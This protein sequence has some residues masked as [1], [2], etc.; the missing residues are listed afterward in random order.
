MSSWSAMVNAVEGMQASSTG[1]SSVSQNIANLNTA[2]YKA[3][4]VTFSDVLSSITPH[5]NIMGVQAV[6]QNQISVQGSIQTTQNWSDVALQ[7]NGFF[8]VNSAEAGS[9][10]TQFTRDGSFV[11]TSLGTTSV[12]TATGTT[13]TSAGATYLTNSTGQFIMGWAAG[14]SPSNSTA[15]LSAVNYTLGAVMAAKSTTAVT[16]GTN[17]PSNAPIY[18]PSNPK[19]GGITATNIPVYDSLGDAGNAQLIWTKSGANAWNAGIQPPTGAAVANLANNSYLNGTRYY[20]S[21]GQLEFSSIPANGS[22][23]TLNSTVAGGQPQTV[24]I[25]FYNSQSGVDPTQDGASLGTSSAPYVLGVDLSS[26]TDT[27]GVASAIENAIGNAANNPA[28][29]GTFG[30]AKL[31]LGGVTDGADRFSATNNILNIVQ[32]PG[33]AAVNVNCV[34]NATTGLGT[35]I[36]QSQVGAGG[37]STPTGQFSIQQIDP[38]YTQ[39][40][41][42]PQSDSFG[43]NAVNSTVVLGTNSF[44]VNKLPPTGTLTLDTA[45]V[46]WATLQTGGVGYPFANASS[47]TQ[48]AANATY[49]I[50]SVAGV[51]GVSATSSGATVTLSTIGSAS[52]AVIPDSAGATGE[53]AWANNTDGTSTESVNP[54]NYLQIGN[55]QI[56]WAQ[57][58]SGQV[59]SY[60][61]AYTGVSTTLTTPLT[62]PFGTTGTNTTAL[63]QTDTDKLAGNIT[64]ALTQLAAVPV[65]IPGGVTATQDTVQANKIDLTSGTS[66]TSVFVSNGDVVWANGQVANKKAVTMGDA[67]GY[68]SAGIGATF[69]G[70]GTVATTIPNILQVYWANGAT[71]Q[72]G[73][74]NNITLNLSGLQQLASSTGVADT[75]QQDGHA[76]GTLTSVSFDNGGVLSGTYSNGKSEVLYTLAVATFTAPNALNPVSGNM[77]AATEGAGAMSINSIG[78]LNGQTSLVT[79]AVEGSNVSVDNEFTNMV[80]MQRAYELNSQVFK[81]GDEMSQRLRDL[82][83]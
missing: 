7:G 44:S 60:A 43:I 79:G 45:T 47:T 71:A 15:T 67:S 82:I 3:S 20:A 68:S 5:A 21:H 76:A 36:V 81:A 8:V 65:T 26:V 40:S 24:K 80:V 18:D 51:A 19:A 37:S 32:S 30:M 56:P 34:S 31:L 25:E 2:G 64:S 70:N 53:V 38:A 48:L 10:K 4:N 6:Q 74:G 27:T 28:A 23:F 16:V 35:S 61:D 78:G 42:A 62:L 39:V 22:Y 29:K 69:N 49:W 73:T 13:T 63:A 46:P 77:F 55:I 72:A 54:G 9:G 14:T 75:T 11:G 57:L 41:A 17:L 66:P 58:V 83:T 1:I 12:T 50:N 59:S 33:A 52:T